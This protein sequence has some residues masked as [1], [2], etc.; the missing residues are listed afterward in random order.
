MKSILVICYL[1]AGVW[2]ASSQDLV[3]SGK[4]TD[5]ATKEAMPY[6]QVNV[7][8]T[9]K[10]CL[11]NAE[12]EFE[13][14]I[15]P[16]MTN[17]TLQFLFMGFKS[18]KMKID[19]LELN[20]PLKI[21]ME[22]NAF[23]LDE[24][25]VTPHPPVYYLRQSMK[26]LPEYYSSSTFNSVVF[27]RELV[28]INGEFYSLSEALLKGYFQPFLTNTG[29]TSRIK[30]LAYRQFSNK[31]VGKPLIDEKKSA[32]RVKKEEKKNVKR[33]KKGEDVEE[34]K[35]D[36][37]E[38]YETFKAFFASLSVH[39]LWDSTLIRSF[40]KDSASFDE[41]YYTQGRML[42]EGDKQIMEIRMHNKKKEDKS[43]QTGHILLDYESLAF[44]ELQVEVSPS[45]AGWVAAKTALLL[46][47]Y[48]IHYLIADITYRYKEENGTYIPSHTSFSIK[49][50]FE[51]I[52]WFNSNDVFN[53]E[54]NTDNVVLESANPADDLCIGGTQLSK[55]KHISDQLKSGFGASEWN[56]YKGVIK[57]ETV[58]SK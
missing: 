21:Q 50:S 57:P 58:F 51:K 56:K 39:N 33:V 15:R 20:E 13:L 2:F 18:M 31:D 45:G 23:Q 40:Y 1:I 37:E 46:F 35:S 54:I 16:E 19:Q 3:I 7:L 28:K 4:V 49:A 42:H 11:T 38:M 27:S 43:A 47:G 10:G 9:S 26:V 5:V 8:G 36:E 48:K 17:D 52:H 41:S 30:V 44:R 34:V 25:I 32:K 53:I 24:V 6:V 22:S 14:G 29:D 55:K 12:G